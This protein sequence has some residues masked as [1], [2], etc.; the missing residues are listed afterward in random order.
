M[1]MARTSDIPDRT[2]DTHG[3]RRSRDRKGSGGR[4]WCSSRCRSRATAVWR[5]AST[6]SVTNSPSQKI[7]I[8]NSW[9]SRVL[10]AMIS[11][12]PTSSHMPSRGRTHPIARLTTKITDRTKP[13]IISSEMF[14]WMVSFSMGSFQ[15]AANRTTAVSGNA[16]AMRS[17]GTRFRH[18]R[19]SSAPSTPTAARL[20]AMGRVAG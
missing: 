1:A 4:E 8:A 7:S 10:G 18:P 3:F 17:W 14:S 6:R 16:H 19:M 12:Q 11:R 15:V 9:G 2:Q 20:A 5:L 13:S